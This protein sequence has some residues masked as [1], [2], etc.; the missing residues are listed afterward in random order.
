MA[1]ETQMHARLSV[2]P[3]L[4]ERVRGLYEAGLIDEAEGFPCVHRCFG[5]WT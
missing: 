5:R 1:S 3:E 2:D 4:R